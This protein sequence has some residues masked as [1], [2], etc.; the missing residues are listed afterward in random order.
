MVGPYFNTDVFILSCIW[1]T[2][3]HTAAD[4]TSWLCEVWWRVTHG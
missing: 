1:P 4:L 2:S 3:D